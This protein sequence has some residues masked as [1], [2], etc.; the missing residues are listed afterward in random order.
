[1]NIGI[2]NNKKT[3]IVAIL[4]SLV[5]VLVYLPAI[6]NDFVNWDDSEYVYGNPNIQY[7]GFKSI[8]WMTTAFHS[9]NW[10][11]LT[12]ISHS[13]DY[14]IWGLN[15]I[16]HHMTSVIFHWLNTLLVV[17]LAVSLINQAISS[18]QTLSID[19]DR[20]FTCLPLIAAAVTGLLFALHPLHVESVAC[21]S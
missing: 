5:T 11:P 12:W 1:M 16:G 9:A 18:K 20:Q 3:V 7:A 8:L 4:I 6:Q 15:P 17:I 13:I 14:A 19:E 2:S 10:H 21:V